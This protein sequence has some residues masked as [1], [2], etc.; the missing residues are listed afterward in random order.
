MVTRGETEM[1]RRM[2]WILVLV[3]V[4]I[5]G[6]IFT[7]EAVREAPTDLDGQAGETDTDTTPPEPPSA[8][9]A[10]GD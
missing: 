3:V 5:L 10:P 2:I 4:V 6:T 1:S 9:A 8:E 7:F